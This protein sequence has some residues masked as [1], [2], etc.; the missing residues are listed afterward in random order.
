VLTGWL[1]NGSYTVPGGPADPLT[2]SFTSVTNNLVALELACFAKHGSWPRSWATYGYTD[3][4]LDPAAFA[5]PINGLTYTVGG[6]K[7][8]A[9]PAAGYKMTV[10]DVTG[11]VRVMTNNLMWSISY[12]ATIGTW[13]YHTT[14]PSDQIDISTLKVT[15]A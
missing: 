8:N 13:Y 11:R 5:S 15:T 1:S 7:V 3:L 6:S 12:D 10:T 14:N 9:R 4:G 2:D